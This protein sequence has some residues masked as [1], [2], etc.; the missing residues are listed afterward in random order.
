MENPLKKGEGFL[1]AAAMVGAMS[2]SAEGVSQQTEGSW[3]IVSESEFVR[4]NIP[5]E[6]IQT[7]DLR[8]NPEAQIDDSKTGFRYI[9]RSGTT[10]FWINQHPGA[11]RLAENHDPAPRTNQPEV[12]ARII[13]KENMEAENSGTVEVKNSQE[14]V[15][16]TPE[17]DEEREINEVIES[18]EL[19]KAVEDFTSRFTITQPW[20]I[21][22]QK[23][24]RH[25]EI[26]YSG[27]YKNPPEELKNLNYAVVLGDSLNKKQ[28]LVQG[29]V[30]SDFFIILNSFTINKTKKA[31]LRYFVQMSLS[32]QYIAPTKQEKIEYIKELLGPRVEEALQRFGEYV[33]PVIAEPEYKSYEELYGP[34]PDIEV[35]TSAEPAREEVEGKDVKLTEEDLEDIFDPED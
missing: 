20:A 12:R 14:E 13:K 34:G 1:K 18:P 22:P 9:D 17:S 11:Q 4:H 23:G 5:A 21:D 6:E 7:I 2:L 27:S 8:Q 32:L 33:P 16:E 29:S 26:S 25:Y 10:Y 3:S 19:T 24:N 15:Q 35:R 28:V 30:T 31:S